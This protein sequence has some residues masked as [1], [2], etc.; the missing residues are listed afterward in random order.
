MTNILI[1]IGYV[2]EDISAGG[3]RYRAT[4]HSGS[5]GR[6]RIGRYLGREAIAAVVRNAELVSEGVEST[7]LSLLISAETHQSSKRSWMWT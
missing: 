1:M 3:G 7:I 5:R 4:S 6:V 2:D